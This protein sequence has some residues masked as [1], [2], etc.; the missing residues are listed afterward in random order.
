MGNCVRCYFRQIS[1]SLAFKK[2]KKDCKI[3][4]IILVP[5]FCPLKTEI[6][7]FSIGFCLNSCSFHLQEILRG[8][9]PRF[10][11]LNAV[12]M[13]EPLNG[14]SNWTQS[15]KCI[16]LP[17]DPYFSPWLGANTWQNLPTD[18]VPVFLATDSYITSTS[19][20]CLTPVRDIVWLTHERLFDSNTHGQL[21]L[22]DSQTTVGRRSS[23]T[24]QTYF[25]SR[26]TSYIL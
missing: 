6:A 9:I 11:T 14:L 8:F 17:I 22:A 12:N 4:K 5:D 3:L 24:R 19:I 26:C 10:C 2:S 15:H 18:S 13:I 20:S 1:I 7:R 16:H 21:K 23:L 25:Q